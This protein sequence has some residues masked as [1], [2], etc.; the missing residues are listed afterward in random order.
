MPVFLLIKINLY[1][2]S[3]QVNLKLYG[4]SEIVTLLSLIIC[5]LYS[6]FFPEFRGNQNLGDRINIAPSLNLCIF[7]QAYLYKM[8]KCVQTRAGC[9]D[10]TRNNQ[11][12]NEGNQKQTSF[13][14]FMHKKWNHII[15]EGLFLL[16]LIAIFSRF[17]LWE[18]WDSNRR[19]RNLGDFAN[20][21]NSQFKLHRCIIVLVESFIHSFWV[22]HVNM[23]AIQCLLMSS[24]LVPFKFLCRGV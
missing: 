14:I 16:L 4:A 18:C 2:S 7:T 8:V 20:L 6:S 21:I 11:N 5:K 22:A 23:F 24:L 15:A 12:S 1:C 9:C 19:D 17:F 10:H 3:L 13:S